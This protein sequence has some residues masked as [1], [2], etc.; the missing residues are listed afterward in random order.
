MSNTEKEVQQK[1]F[2]IFNNEELTNA[3]EL[4]KRYAPI[5]VANGVVLVDL[6]N[7]ELSDLELYIKSCYAGFVYDFFHPPPKTADDFLSTGIKRKADQLTNNKQKRR[8]E[9][10]LVH[11]I[12]WNIHGKD[13]NTDKKRDAFVFSIE[14]YDI[15]FIIEPGSNLIKGGDE[16]AK[17]VA[18]LAEK[19]PNNKFVFLWIE[20][21][22]GGNKERIVV[23]YRSTK[24]E[25]KR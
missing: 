13:I 5:L 8:K 3:E 11:V 18:K 9:D 10:H 22:K 25:K 12:S 14:L 23:A 19:D 1:L 21:K 17:I 20:I 15:I 16:A 7:L 24:I 6:P 4:S 2:E